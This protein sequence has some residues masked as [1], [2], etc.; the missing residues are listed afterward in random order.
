[1]KPEIVERTIMEDFLSRCGLEP[2]HLELSR[3]YKNLIMPEIKS[4]KN[5]ELCFVKVVISKKRYV[6][7]FKGRKD[8]MEKE[9]QGY[10]ENPALSPPLVSYGMNPYYVLT[11][12]SGRGLDDL[13]PNELTE[14]LFFKVGVNLRELKRN[15]GDF[16][17]ANIILNEVPYDGPALSRPDAKKSVLSI[18]YSLYGE[19][20]KMWDLANLLTP[21]IEDAKF[22][23]K[24]ELATKGT[25][26]GFGEQVS[27]N[28]LEKR[29]AE[30][31]EDE[32]AVKVI[33]E[34]V[35][36]IQNKIN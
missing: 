33:M 1:M 17:P 34:T 18:D 19:R 32:H 27:I 12:Y 3:T 10:L 7:V 6:Y 11:A 5:A 30:R 29:I 22:F 9:A 15:H 14:E 4:G 8:E 21:M 36:K 35:R 26:A 23:G 31:A 24:L 20:D 25:L 13:S 16:D 2:E 28:E